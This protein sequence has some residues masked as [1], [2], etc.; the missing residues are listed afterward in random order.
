MIE[1]MIP[2][3]PRTAPLSRD[4]AFGFPISANPSTVHARKGSGFV[5][6]KDN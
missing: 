2:H 4:R 6:R 3:P 1:M 5:I